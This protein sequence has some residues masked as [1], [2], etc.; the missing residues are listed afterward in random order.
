MKSKK[1]TRTQIEAEIHALD[2]CRKF[3]PKTNYLGENNHALLDVGISALADRLTVDMAYDMAGANETSPADQ[4]RINAALWMAGQ[5][6]EVPSQ[7]WQHFKPKPAL[8][9]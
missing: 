2:E 4:T 5:S 9:V 3:I 1:P 6:D 8:T 7:E